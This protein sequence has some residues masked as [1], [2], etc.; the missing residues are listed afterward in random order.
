MAGTINFAEL[1]ANNEKSFAKYVDCSEKDF[2]HCH[3]AVQRIIL[4]FTKTETV[5]VS[6]VNGGVSTVYMDVVDGLS[7]EQER[8]IMMLQDLHNAWIPM[9]HERMKCTEV[10]MTEEEKERKKK[11]DKMFE[12]YIQLKQKQ[13]HANEVLACL[14]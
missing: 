13:E 10:L 11:E 14:E 8:A 5:V 9:K 6:D 1:L 4:A 7:K 2:E 12:F 3:E